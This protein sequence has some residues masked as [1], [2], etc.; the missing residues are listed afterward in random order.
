M[1]TI[2]HIEWIDVNITMVKLV[3]TPLKK[4]T[5]G[6]EKVIYFTDGISMDETITFSEQTG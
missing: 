1:A 4:F 6:C 5:Y 2:T 3:T